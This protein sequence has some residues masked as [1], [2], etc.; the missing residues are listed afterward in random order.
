MESL[1][2]TYLML[3]DA[4]STDFIRYLHDEINWDS[5][6][7]SVLGARGVG[8]TTMLLQHI[9]LHEDIASSIYVTADDFYFSRHRLFDFAKQFYLNGGK[10][11]FIDEVHKYPEW[12]RELKNIYDLIPGLQVVYTGSSI[13]D[14][15]KGGADLSRRKVSYKLAGLSFREYIN[16][17]QGWN[18]K[19]YSIDEILSG[20]VVLPGRDV[21]PLALFKEYLQR[22]YYPFFKE[23][24]YELRLRSVINQ[25]VENDIPMFASMPMASAV[26]LKKLLYVLAQSAPFK[27]NYSKLERDLEIGRNTLPDY[28]GYLEKAGLLNI[29]R[30]KAKGI[31]MLEK[32]DK[33]YLNNPNMAFA[34][35][36]ATPDVGAVRETIF[37][38]WMQVHNF[39]T[40]S[41]V[42]D[43]EI[44]GR[45]FEVGGRNKTGRQLQGVTNGYIVKDNIEFASGNTVPLWMF[46]FN[47]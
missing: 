35:Q 43:F 11:I 46:G 37:L 8:K 6:M 14:L 45:T 12:S 38:A 34:L 39:V 15:E 41:P 47:Y 4:T 25:M 27:P 44:D 5:R 36:E 40:S 3:L 26:K 28:V 7:V 16:I 21:R 29:L 1:K 32:I 42:S 19:P 18:I 17:S 13:L 33:I 9:K 22:G 31:K 23:P 10:K 24:E 20:G 2:Q 30:E